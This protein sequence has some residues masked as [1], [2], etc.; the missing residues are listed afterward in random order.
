MEKKIIEVEDSMGKNIS[1]FK[2]AFKYYLLE[3]KPKD[4]TYLDVLN[5]IP[6][7]YS[8]AFARALLIKMSYWHSTIFKMS[9]RYDIELMA[10]FL[11]YFCSHT[12]AL[13]CI[14]TKQLEQLFRDIDRDIKGHIQAYYYD[15]HNRGFSNHETYTKKARESID[16]IMGNKNFPKKLI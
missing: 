4:I 2:E 7:T 3:E 16:I 8:K 10:R 11:Q 1:L 6:A 15:G 9:N 5:S 14:A 12:E 13:K